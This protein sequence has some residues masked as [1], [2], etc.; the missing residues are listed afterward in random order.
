MPGDTFIPTRLF[1]I[2]GHPL[3]HSLSPLIHNRAFRQA[4]LDNVY[5]AWPVKP[6]SLTD[7][8]TACRTLPISGV[9]VTIPHKESV[10]D[11]VDRVTEAGSSVGGAGSPNSA[12]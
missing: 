11:L 10:M 7:F 2:I 1:G 6:G 3:G 5:M 4:G 8:I 9:S 12:L